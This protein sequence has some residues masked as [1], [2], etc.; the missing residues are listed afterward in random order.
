ML[1]CKNDYKRQ[2]M[3]KAT[4]EPTTRRATE[5]ICIPPSQILLAWVTLW[6]TPEDAPTCSYRDLL[7]LHRLDLRPQQASSGPLRECYITHTCAR[8]EMATGKNPLGITCPYPYPRRKNTSA[9]KPIPMTDIKFC[10]NPYP[11]GFRVPNGFPV[12]TNINI[13]NNSSYK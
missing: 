10:P 13:K 11:C 5:P 2:K 6:A 7:S 3:H 1:A 12:P 8:V 4:D 9:K